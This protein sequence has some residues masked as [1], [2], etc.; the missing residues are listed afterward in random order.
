MKLVHSN[1]KANLAT[2]PNIGDETRVT[3]DY[4]FRAYILIILSCFLFGCKTIP[5]ENRNETIGGGFW[6]QDENTDPRFIHKS[7][8]K[9]KNIGTLY[10]AGNNVLINGSKV[11][12]NSLIIKNNSFVSTGSQSSVRIELEDN[13]ILCHI[14][15]EDFST[16]RGYGDTANCQHNIGTRHVNSQIL[17][18]IYHYDVTQH[19]TEITVLKGSIVISTRTNPGKVVKVN[20]GEEAIILEDMIIGPRPV[21]PDEISRRILWRNNFQFYKN[22]IDWLVAGTTLFAITIA[23]LLKIFLD[24]DDDPPDTTRS[25]RSSILC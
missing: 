20:S 6:E 22:K 10:I 11:K 9:D 4:I 8:S 14:Y 12:G 21:S 5:I 15:I 23:I 17:N 1:F 19:Q 24:S 13:R 16:G 25:C 7:L 2:Y 3:R 18:A